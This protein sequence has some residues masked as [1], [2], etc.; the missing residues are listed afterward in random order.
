MKTWLRQ[1]LFA[2]ASAL[3]H[4]FKPRSGFLLNVLVVAI[5]LALPFCSCKAMHTFCNAVSEENRL[6]A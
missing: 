2:L 4:L 1:H 3:R 6:C 5:A